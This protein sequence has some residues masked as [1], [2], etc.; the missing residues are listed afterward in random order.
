MRVNLR[1]G[2]RVVEKED[3]RFG[4]RTIAYDSEHGFYLNGRHVK[5]Y[6]V[7]MHH[8]L[9]CLGA[10]INTVAIKRQLSIL[11]RMGVNAVR[12]AHN[13]AAPELIEAADEMGILINAE[14]FDMWRGRK[15]EYDYARFFDEW[16]ERDVASWV[17]RDRNHPSIVMWCIGNEI[18]D[19]HGDERGQETTR[20]LMEYVYAHDP[21]H[22]AP[23][24]IG[25]NYMQIGR[26]HV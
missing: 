1:E 13:M 21:R 15:T 23:V 10:A 25:S 17:R 3:I 20:M 22:N 26:A 18:Y 19:T 2:E 4:V 16:A 5:F 8:D 9:G 12:T 24:T 11:K 6:G 7:C 14:S